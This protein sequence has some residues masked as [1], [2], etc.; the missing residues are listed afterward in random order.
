MEP[1]FEFH[2]YPGT[3]NEQAATMRRVWDLL[4]GFLSEADEELPVREFERLANE[5]L[6]LAMNVF[7]GM[8]TIA[9]AQIRSRAEDLGEDPL[10]V[11]RNYERAFERRLEGLDG[12]EEDS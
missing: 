2:Q 8:T 4:A 3:P 7:F 5:D 10:D 1:H 6:G 12:D 9:A 11:I